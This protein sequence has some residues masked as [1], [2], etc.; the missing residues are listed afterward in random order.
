VALGYKGAWI[1]EAC[2]RRMKQTGLELEFARAVTPA[3]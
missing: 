2:F 1:I 3:S